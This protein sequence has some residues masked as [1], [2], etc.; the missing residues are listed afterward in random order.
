MLPLRELVEKL[1]E[2]TSQEEMDQVRENLAPSGACA[3]TDDSPCIAHA[4]IGKREWCVGCGRY[5]DRCVC[6]EDGS[7]VREHVRVP[8]LA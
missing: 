3:C 1:S 8:R 6:K 4:L 7:V 2:V 5:T